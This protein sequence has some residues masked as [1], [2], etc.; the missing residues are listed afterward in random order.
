MTGFYMEYNTGLKWVLEKNSESMFP[1][2]FTC[3]NRSDNIAQWHSIFVF[4]CDFN[5]KVKRL[6]SL[7]VTS[8]DVCMYHKQIG[9]VLPCFFL[10]ADRLIEKQDFTCLRTVLGSQQISRKIKEK[11][12]RKFKNGL[13]KRGIDLLQRK[14]VLKHEIWS[15]VNFKKICNFS[16]LPYCLF[17]TFFTSVIYITK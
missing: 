15:V 13:K 8:K 10:P 3:S 11:E 7:C 12:M 14:K 16:I 5:V 1:C 9:F 17:R 6:V 4:S 2:L